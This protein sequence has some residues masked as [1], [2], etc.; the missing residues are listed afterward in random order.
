M[1]GQVAVQKPQWMQARRIASASW[2][3]GVRPRN[4]LEPLPRISGGV[5]ASMAVRILFIHFFLAHVVLTTLL[6]ARGMFSDGPRAK[7]LGS[8]FVA[9]IILVAG[10][11]GEGGDITEK[12]VMRVVLIGSAALYIVAALSVLD[13]FFFRSAGRTAA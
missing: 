12:F 2:P 5:P 4:R 13:R 11:M 1:V 7:H 3:S 8:V 10:S 9:L 6:F